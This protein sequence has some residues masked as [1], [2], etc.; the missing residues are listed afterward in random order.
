MFP[1]HQLID[2]S[3][4]LEHAA[5]S[6]PIPPAIHYVTH[7]AEGLAQ[8]RQFFGVAPEDLV[9][10]NGQGWAIEETASIFGPLIL[11]ASPASIAKS[12]SW[13]TSTCCRHTGSTFPACL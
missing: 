11:R 10:S 8:M 3:V 1:Q 9:Y 13:Q 2:L 7:E 4:P 12:K 6:E 5:V